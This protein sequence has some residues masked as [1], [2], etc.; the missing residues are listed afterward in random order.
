MDYPIQIVR[1]YVNPYGNIAA[2]GL[3]R[4]YITQDMAN[5]F[6]F[7]MH[8]RQNPRSVGQQFLA[9]SAIHL[10]KMSKDM[11]YN[12][13]SKFLNTAPV[14]EIDVLYRTK[15][16]S[17]INLLDASASGVR[18]IAAPS[19][20]SPSGVSQIWVSEVSSLEDFYYNVTPTRV[21]ITASGDY[22]PSVNNIEWNIIPSGIL[23]KDSKKYDVWKNKHDI[24]WCYA[25][26][27]F[28]KQD[29]ETLEDYETYILNSGYGT[30]INMLFSDGFL[31]WV[32]KDGSSYYLNMTSTKTQEPIAVN[33]DM[34]VSFDITGKFDGLEPSGILM[35]HNR[36][37]SICD[38][39]KTRIFEVCPRYDYFTLDKISRY[40]YFREDYRNSGVFISNT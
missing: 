26:N 12:I 16:P 19:G 3:Y 36:N 11:E 14:E 13:K 39:N 9:A 8:L 24:T 10:E 35:D 23:D 6:P 33:L 15:I 5:D 4:S 31:W 7:W 18:C 32:G 2:S 30:P 37:L 28:R 1:T 34:I 38:T 25:D 21:E 29:I 40:I 22:V 27:Y 20:C 17:N